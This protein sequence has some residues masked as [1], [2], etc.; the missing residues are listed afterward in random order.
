MMASSEDFIFSGAGELLFHYKWGDPKY[1][2]VSTIGLTVQPGSVGNTGRNIACDETVATPLVS[3][4]QMAKMDFA[5]LSSTIDGNGEILY[6]PA[7]KSRS[8]P[9]QME[10]VA[11]FKN[12]AD[13]NVKEFFPAGTSIPDPPNY[14]QEVDL[15]L[16][17]CDA[18]KFAI[19]KTEFW[20]ASNRLVRFVFGDPAVGVRLSEFVPGSPF[21]AM[22]EI[23]CQKGYAGVGFRLVEDKGLIVAAEVF[24]G[25]PAA[26]AGVV[27][28]DIVSHID[29]E[30][31]SGLTLQQ[32]IEK[33]RGPE[34]TKVLLKISRKGSDSFEL[35]IPRE[36]VK[37][38]SVEGAPK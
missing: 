31:V 37:M 2:S 1:L 28:N 4:K 13:R 9:N 33:V 36:I 16:I 18:N 23:V 8:D 3:K 6:G 10:V 38:K 15:I 7:R 11:I 20:D 24:E 26:K 34:G 17:R 29:N 5:S 21:A 30:P 32:I 35:L 12:F 19:T 14:R 22:Q 25:S 27:A